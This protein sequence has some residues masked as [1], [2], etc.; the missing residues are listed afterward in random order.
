MIILLTNDDGIYAPGLR[1]LRDVLTDLGEIWVVAP[2][3]QQSGTGHAFSAFKPLRVKEVKQ[4]GELFGYAVSGTPADTVKIALRHIL[5]EPPALVVSGINNGENG[6]INILYSGT[7]AAAMEAAIVGIPA[8]AVSVIYSSEQDY[9][10]SAN[11]AH[12]ICVRILEN[13]LPFGTML[14]VNIPALPEEEIRGVKVV[15]QAVS[16]YHEEIERRT[17]PRGVDYYWIGGVNKIVSDGKDSDMTAIREGY[18]AI[19][20]LHAR[21]TDYEMIP[22]IKEWDLE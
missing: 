10:F 17:D 22:T 8:I 1:A 15:H 21:F 12:K 20:P 2:T 7:V 5:P 3:R 4:D 13:G 19:T 9:R 18:V 16:H 11:F 14:S 6:G